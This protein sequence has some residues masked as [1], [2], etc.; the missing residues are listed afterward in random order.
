MAILT[1]GVI[2]VYISLK[3]KAVWHMG[4][5]RDDL[6]DLRADVEALLDNLLVFARPFSLSYR[7]KWVPSA[8]VYETDEDIVVTAELAGIPRGDV[9]VSIAGDVL[10]LTGVRREARSYQRRQYHSMEIRF[11]PFEKL[12][13]LPTG[14]QPDKMEVTFENGLL[15]I[16][17][18]KVIRPREIIVEIE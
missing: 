2:W 8:D 11:G 7:R 1:G 18:P 5:F 12:I 9:R 15:E 13:P 10:Y 3:R 17:L 16:R 4:D 14:V 6:R